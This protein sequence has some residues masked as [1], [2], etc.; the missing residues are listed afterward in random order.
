MLERENVTVPYSRA[1]PAVEGM[2]NWLEWLAEDG[3]H[4]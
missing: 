1:T 4:R 2:L 3:W